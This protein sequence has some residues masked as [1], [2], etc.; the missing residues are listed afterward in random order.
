MQLRAWLLMV[1]VSS[2]SALVG[3]GGTPGK[4]AVDTPALPYIAPDISEIT[5]IE[6]PDEEEPEEE[7]SPSAMAEP[8]KSAPAPASA[9]EPAKPAAMPAKAATPA[10]PAAAAKGTQPA[11]A[12]AAARKAAPSAGATPAPEPKK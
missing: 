8:A 12:P 7:T 3:C 2:V 4:L 5:G 10:K 11:T 6:E 1:A 9:A